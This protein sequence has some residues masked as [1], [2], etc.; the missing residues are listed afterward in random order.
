MPAMRRS[1]SSW[2]K[3]TASFGEKT[4]M[5]KIIAAAAFAGLAMTGVAQAQ[6]VAAGERVFARCRACHQL[7]ETARN[8]V[9]PVLNGLFGRQAGSIPG[10]NYS[11][12]NKASGVTWT[13]EVFAQYIKNP[14]QFMPGNRM[15]FNGIPNDQ[16]IKDITAFL[17]TWAPDGKRITQ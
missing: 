16:E 8:G 11:P 1:S 10:F 14:R 3:S 13:E 15:A 2:Q 12:A 4:I 5:K 9:G 6:D 7:G 17:K